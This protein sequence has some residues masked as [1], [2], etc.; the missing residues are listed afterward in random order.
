MRGVS[1][2]GEVM[3]N[4][5]QYQSAKGL[6]ITLVILFAILLLLVLAISGC[7]LSE[8]VMIKNNINAGGDAQLPATGVALAHFAVGSLWFVF[9][10]I[11]AI[12]FC[13]WIYR[14]NCNARALGANDMSI[15]PGWS[16]GWFFV[17][18]AN[19]VKPFVAVREIWNA[20]DSDPRDVSASGSAALIVSAWW[21]TWLLSKSASGASFRMSISATTPEEH[22][23]AFYFNLASDILEVGATILVIG[24]VSGIHERQ[25]R[26]FAGLVRIRPLQRRSRTNRRGSTEIGGSHRLRL[27]PRLRRAASW[28]EVLSAGKALGARFLDVGNLFAQCLSLWTCERADDRILPMRH[29]LPAGYLR[30]H[31]NAESPPL[32]SR[33]RFLVKREYG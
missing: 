8:C 33:C 1:V 11:T 13:V 26:L 18:F 20:S 12:V 3:A 30:A 9:Y 14:A 21:I 19:L 24:V 4:G 15:T 22:L 23:Y 16:A 10:L 31:S 29:A 25:E 28:Q 7:L 32:P 5:W 6:A 2:L 17:P 27:G